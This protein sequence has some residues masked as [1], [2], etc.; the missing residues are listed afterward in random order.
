M[1][2]DRP[3]D[4]ENEPAMSPAPDADGADDPPE[5]STATDDG[6]NVARLLNYLLLAGL[7]VF[8]LAAAVQ[9][10]LNAAATIG[11]WVAPAYRSAFQAAFNLAVLLV[12]VAGASRQLDRVR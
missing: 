12:T 8:A 2:D 7:S 9:F 10:Y 6:R 5:G 4:A 1:S 3:T 11:R